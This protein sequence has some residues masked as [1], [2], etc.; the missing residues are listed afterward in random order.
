MPF[1][2]EVVHEQRNLFDARPEKLCDLR[3]QLTAI[4]KR[5]EGFHTALAVSHRINAYGEK[6]APGQA[7]ELFAVSFLITLEPVIKQHRRAR[8]RIMRDRQKRNPA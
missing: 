4:E 5:G 3:H 1:G 8:A 7:L 2:G 6:A